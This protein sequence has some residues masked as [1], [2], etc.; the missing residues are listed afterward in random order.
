MR[1]QGYFVGSVSYIVL[2]FKAKPVLVQNSALDQR[3]K[4]H[5]ILFCT[6][7]TKIKLNVQEVQMAVYLLQVIEDNEELSHDCNQNFAGKLFV[8]LRYDLMR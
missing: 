3:R 8:N 7:L 4:Q 2:R 6:V 5:H 1:Y